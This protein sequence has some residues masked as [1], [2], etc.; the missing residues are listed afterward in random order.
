MTAAWESL[1]WDSEF[2]GVPIGRVDLDRVPVEDL[3]TMEA[4]ARD[5]G[6]LCLYG[7]LAPEPDAPTLDVQRQ[8]YRFVEAA[9][10]FSLRTTEPLIPRPEGIEVR[11]GTV[12]DLPALADTVARLAPWSRYAVDP[13]FGLEAAER[14]QARWIERAAE[15]TTGERALLVAEDDSGII[16][17]ITRASDPE[18]VVDTVGT[19]SRGSGAARYLIQQARDW[20]GDRALYGGP[21][22]ARNVA[23]LRYVSHCGYRVARVRYL[24]HRWLDE[25]VDR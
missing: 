15:C 10:L 9:T 17:F 23:A 3:A 6:V 7:S 18:P 2:F 20:A 1:P 22:A 21:I 19:S 5:A 16:A 25:E 24:Y 8:G 4:E 11:E 12:A 14:L 13:R